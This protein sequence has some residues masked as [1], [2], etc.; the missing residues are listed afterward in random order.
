MIL[1]IKVDTAGP[2]MQKLYEA[3]KTNTK[4]MG[5]ISTLM[6]ISTERNFKAEGR[7]KWEGL[8]A[9]TIKSRE[10]R[11]KWPGK[12]LQV[13]GMLAASVHP[14]H[15]ENEAIVGTNIRYGKIQQLGGTVSIPARS[16]LYNP[17]RKT[18][19]KGKGQFKKGTTPGRGATFGA[20]SVTIPA[21]PYLNLHPAEVV[22]IT[23]RVQGF[24]AT[25]TK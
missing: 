24:Y 19:G 10:R 3:T 15:R 13:S 21:R 2:A 22:E 7:P 1:E 14:A 25:G 12:K 16:A 17:K 20:H 5:D 6:M 9:S 23:D 18:R 8:A 11:G 4:L